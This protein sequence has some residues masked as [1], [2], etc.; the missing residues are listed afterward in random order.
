[1]GSET[2]FA[3]DA[4]AY[5]TSRATT[6]GRASRLVL[7]LVAVAFLA[8]FLVLPLVAV[9]TEALRQGLAA[10]F[11]A[12]FEPD[13]LAA[14]RLTLTVAAIAVPLNLVF[15]LAAAWATAKFEFRGKG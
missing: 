3:A 4:A 12:L 13:A 5:P 7:T 9:F 2:L 1:M 15:G 14:V 10:Y 8:L 6:E 11:D